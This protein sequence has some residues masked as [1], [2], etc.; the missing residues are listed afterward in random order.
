MRMPMS[1]P[2]VLWKGELVE[3]SRFSDENVQEIL[4]RACPDDGNRIMTTYKELCEKIGDKKRDTGEPA[5]LH[6]LAVALGMILENEVRD[7]DVIEAAFLHDAIEDGHY[8][9]DELETKYANREKVWKMVES[10][11]KPKREKSKEECTPSELKAYNRDA[12]AGI[13]VAHPEYAAEC[14]E[15]K[16]KDRE[17]NIR[18]LPLNDMERCIDYIRETWEY[19]LLLADIA[20]ERMHHNSVEQLANAIGEQIERLFDDE[21]NKQIFMSELFTSIDKYYR[22][23]IEKIVKPESTKQDAT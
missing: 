4:E 20:D 21:D 19:I 1:A 22:S 9:L 6:P 11:T 16:E 18:T 12:F 14:A 2:S 17:K 13:I 3:A 8:T 7:P 15:L 23:R 10:M 5:H